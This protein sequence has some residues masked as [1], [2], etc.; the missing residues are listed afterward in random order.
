LDEDDISEVASKLAAA[1]FKQK[2]LGKLSQND[3]LLAKLAPATIKD[4]MENQHLLGGTTGYFFTFLFYVVGLRRIIWHKEALVL[5][6]KVGAG[7]QKRQ[8]PGGLA[9]PSSLFSV[10]CSALSLLSLCSLS[11]LSALCSALC[12]AL[13]GLCSLLSPSR[14][15]LA[16]LGGRLLATL[17]RI[18]E[19]ELSLEEVLGKGSF[20]VVRRATWSRAIAVGKERVHTIKVAVKMPRVTEVSAF[21]VSLFPLVCFSLLSSSLSSQK[22]FIAQIKAREE[23][24]RGE[25]RGEQREKR[26]EKRR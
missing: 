4:F 3:L 9:L 21:F 20:S 16:S 18:P 1:K 11:A 24:Q 19:E 7:E 10:L 12:S 22:I 23:K 25:K 5:A 13:S 17:A 2:H 8:E 26:G 6:S 15:L 14:A